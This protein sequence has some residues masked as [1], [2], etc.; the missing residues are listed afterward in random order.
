MWQLE[1]GRY[2][3]DLKR[4]LK[5]L[6]PEELELKISELEDLKRELK[7]GY[8]YNAGLP[9]NGEDLK[10]ELKESL[11]GNDCCGE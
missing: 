9:H 5:A 4:E 2:I 1:P 10:G 3:E 11:P 7:D 6:K 8:H